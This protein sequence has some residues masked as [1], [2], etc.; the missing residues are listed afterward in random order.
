MSI[1]EKLLYSSACTERTKNRK[2][3]FSTNQRCA[4]RFSNT[5]EEQNR[6]ARN[7]SSPIFHSKKQ[8]VFLFFICKDTTASAVFLLLSYF[9]H[10]VFVILILNNHNINKNIFILHSR[11]QTKESVSRKGMRLFLNRLCPSKYAR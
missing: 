8:T 10:L 2:N 5:D 1:I 3:I 4:R 6:L 7:S 11:S 9:T